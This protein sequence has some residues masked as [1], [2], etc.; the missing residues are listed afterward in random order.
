[1]S[2]ATAWGI[3]LNFAYFVIGAV[4]L[5]LVIDLIAGTAPLWML[6]MAG[7]GLISGGWRFI[8]EAKAVNRHFEARMAGRFGRL[9][10][11]DALDQP[12]GGRAEH[13]SERQDSISTE[14]DSR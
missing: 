1:M 3:G 7:V 4:V 5:G 14:S 12:A 6:I 2:A 11:D 13:H 10:V 8:R 9:P